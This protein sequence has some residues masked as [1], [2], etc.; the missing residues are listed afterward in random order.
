MRTSILHQYKIARFKELSLEI[1]QDVYFD[2]CD[3]FAVPNK[4]T[5]RKAKVRAMIATRKANQIILCNF[6]QRI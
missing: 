2:M 5:E 1:Y 6:I 4:E 3:K